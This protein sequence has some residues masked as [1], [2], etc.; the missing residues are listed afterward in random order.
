LG[1]LFVGIA[2]PLL[3]TGYY[4]LA[5]GLALA[6]LLLLFVCA[7]DPASALRASA[8]L[9]RWATIGSLTLVGLVYMGTAQVRAPDG[10]LLVE[11]SFF[12]VLRVSEERKGSKNHHLKL[13]NGTTLHGVQFHSG[14]R[15]ELPTLYYGRATAIGLVMG[16]REESTASRVG[17]I[18]L[19]IGTLAAYGREGDVFRFYEIDPVVVRI[20]EEDG[21]FDYLSQS[22]ATIEL[23]VGDARLSIAQEQAQGVEQ[24]F[25]ILVLDAFSSDA[26]PVHLLT[27]EAFAHYAD[28]LADDGLL[29]IHVSNRQ[30]DL[31]P[32]VARQG[33]DAGMEGLQVRTLGAPRYQSTTA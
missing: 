4:E 27:R 25:D 6:W 22:L 26:V 29:A 13:R 5:L 21:P 31:L 15:R 30:F 16:L 20:A 7:H 11:R 14:K 3:F 17:V 18:G 23:V 28:A 8:P 10:V 24:D 1:G 12:G 19:G 2:A 33:L 32:I 9:W